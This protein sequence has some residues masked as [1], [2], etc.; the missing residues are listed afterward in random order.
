MR[1]IQGVL[2][3]RREQWFVR[4]NFGVRRVCNENV[5]DV[6]RADEEQGMNGKRLQKRWRGC[7]RNGEWVCAEG[8]EFGGVCAERVGLASG[9]GG[10]CEEGQVSTQGEVESVE[11]CGLK[12]FRVCNV[13]WMVSM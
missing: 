3:T 13:G 5:K 7:V 8:Q 10:T 4:I 12:V 6:G 11:Q 1:S 2:E 9:E